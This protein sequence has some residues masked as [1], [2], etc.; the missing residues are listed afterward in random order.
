MV[1]KYNCNLTPWGCSGHLPQHQHKST[2]PAIDFWNLKLAEGI[3]TER[4]FWFSCLKWVKTYGADRAVHSCVEHINMLSPSFHIWR[5]ILLWCIDCPLVFGPPRTFVISG[6]SVLAALPSVNRTESDQWILY[7]DVVFIMYDAVPPFIWGKYT[8]L[9]ESFSTQLV[10]PWTLYS[11][12]LWTFSCTGKL[13]RLTTKLQ[14]LQAI[15]FTITHS[16]RDTYWSPEVA[17]LER[18]GHVGA[19]RLPAY[20]TTALM[21]GFLVWSA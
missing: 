8:K 20:S 12:Q 19:V 15:T 10:F 5:H 17:T 14:V 18:V 11:P 3:Q 16:A 2:V 9:L 21:E 13:I 1:T 6:V 4:Q 7:A